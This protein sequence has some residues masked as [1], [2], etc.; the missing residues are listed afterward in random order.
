MDERERAWLEA[1][2][3]RWQRA[4]ALA[5]L[6]PEHDVSGLYHTLRNFERTPAERLARGLAHGRLRP[7]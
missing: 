6:H 5:A 7:R 4:H 3:R 2:E 1:D